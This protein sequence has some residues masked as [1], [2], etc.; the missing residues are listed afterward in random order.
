M[1]GKTVVITLQPHAFGPQ[2]ITY[3]HHSIGVRDWNAVSRGTVLWLKL[4]H[5][6]YASNPL[7]NWRPDLGIGFCGPDTAWSMAETCQ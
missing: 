4:P 5:P 6:W 7:P 2:H 3:R 1:K